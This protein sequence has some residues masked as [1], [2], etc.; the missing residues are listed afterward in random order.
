[1]QVKVEEVEM[2]TPVDPPNNPQQVCLGR[3]KQEEREEQNRSGLHKVPE[4]TSKENISHDKT[5]ESKDRGEEQ[6]SLEESFVGESTMEQSEDDGTEQ[7][8]E[9]E[10]RINDS[11]MD[12]L[13]RD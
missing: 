6:G 13:S 11:A 9:E 10:S 5:E 8:Q 2:E 12:G 3:I 7:D 1:M 4:Q